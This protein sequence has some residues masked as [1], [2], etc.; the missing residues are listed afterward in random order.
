[1]TI[2]KKIILKFKLKFKI[3]VNYTSYFER[4]LI[5]DENQMF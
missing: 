4:W 3:R 1:L 2:F 5:E